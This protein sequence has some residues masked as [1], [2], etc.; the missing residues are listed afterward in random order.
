MNKLEAIPR[1]S[2]ISMKE[3][4]KEILY[5]GLHNIINTNLFPGKGW[6]YTNEQIQKTIEQI[7][8]EYPEFI[9]ALVSRNLL[10]ICNNLAEGIDFWQKE[11]INENFNLRYSE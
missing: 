9:E 6:A 3:Y 4:T 10:N 11:A 7:L 8:E 1:I 2:N 5:H